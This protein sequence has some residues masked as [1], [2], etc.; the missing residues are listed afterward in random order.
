MKVKVALSRPKA[1]EQPIALWNL[2]HQ[3]HLHLALD[4]LSG[5][6]PVLRS[7]CCFQSTCHLIY[8]FVD[9]LWNTQVWKHVLLL[10]LALVGDLGGL[11]L[12]GDW[13]PLNFLPNSLYMCVWK[14][15]VPG[16]SIFPKT[17]ILQSFFSCQS[18]VY[19]TRYVLVLWPVYV[20]SPFSPQSQYIGWPN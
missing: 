14:M 3:H 12:W 17:P 16:P 7:S 19:R 11:G 4:W 2:R 9:L 10:G 13:G 1:P 20:C 5:R 8:V 18:K 15:P 6:L